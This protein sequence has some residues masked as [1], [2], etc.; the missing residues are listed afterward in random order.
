MDKKQDKPHIVYEKPTYNNIRRQYSK[1]EGGMIKRN[2][3]NTNKKKTRVM[4]LISNK[5]DFR[6]GLLLKMK[7]NII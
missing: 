3:A 1:I 4:I 7:K 5:V 2:Y 6:T